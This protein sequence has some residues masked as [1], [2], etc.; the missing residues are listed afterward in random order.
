MNTM[1]IIDGQGGG[2]FLSEAI[3]ELF[4]EKGMGEL[5][6][7]LWAKFYKNKSDNQ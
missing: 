3:P 5:E 4:P 7:L 6:L 1:A 2:R